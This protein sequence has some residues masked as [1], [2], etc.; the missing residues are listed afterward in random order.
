MFGYRFR[1][2]HIMRFL[3]V[4]KPDDA[5]RRPAIALRSRRISD[6]HF[7]AYHRS[8]LIRFWQISAVSETHNASISGAR[9]ERPLDALVGRL[10]VIVTLRCV[11]FPRAV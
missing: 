5:V 9:Y 2:R 11:Q 7:I 3:Y 1:A 6:P 10:L 8:A 4:S